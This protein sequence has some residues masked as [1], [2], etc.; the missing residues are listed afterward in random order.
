MI[1]E[2]AGNKSTS[3][4]DHDTRQ[5]QL[6]SVIEETAAHKSTMLDH[7]SRLYQL[8]NTMDNCTCNISFPHDYDTRILRIQAETIGIISTIKSLEDTTTHFV[9]STSL[10][11]EKMEALNTTIQQLAF[12]ISANEDKATVTLSRFEAYVLL[13]F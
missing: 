12:A 13:R 8:Q 9:D 5:F 10:E 7:D 11:K 1:E 6:Q 3:L 2:T 4:L